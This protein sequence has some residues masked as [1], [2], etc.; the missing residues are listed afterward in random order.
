MSPNLQRFSIGKME[1]FGAQMMTSVRGGGESQH[2]QRAGV[3]EIGG[4]V[5][6]GEI[7]FEGSNDSGET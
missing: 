5:C 2:M 4:K 1:M 3:E 7:A 6:W